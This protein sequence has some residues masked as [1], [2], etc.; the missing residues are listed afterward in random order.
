MHEL[1]VNRLFMPAQKKVWLGELTVPPWPLTWD[2]K[3]QN[4]QTNL[5][6]QAHKSA[7]IW[8]YHFNIWACW[9][10][11][12]IWLA[13]FIIFSRYKLHTDGLWRL[14]TVRYESIELSASS[15]AGM[16]DSD[17]SCQS[18]ANV[19]IDNNIVQMDENE[20]DAENIDANIQQSRLTVSASSR[21]IT[22]DL[23][24][25]DDDHRDD[26]SVEARDEEDSVTEIMLT[27]D[28]EGRYIITTSQN[29]EQGE[30]QPISLPENK[31][32]EE[33]MYNLQMLGDVALKN[34][35]ESTSVLW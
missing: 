9:I 13:T 26:V 17:D 24:Y 8:L 34:Q 20:L 6:V 23:K 16:K 1:L 22:K 7:C 25:F 5:N 10:F 31:E 35:T 14:Q 11:L 18:L 21:E 4:K 28:N 2:V 29:S 27:T 30:G 15:E 33:S 32:F 12:T 19:N 3:Q